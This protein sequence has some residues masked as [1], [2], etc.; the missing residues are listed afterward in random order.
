MSSSCS[1]LWLEVKDVWFQGLKRHRKRVHPVLGVDGAW[2][3]GAQTGG[4]EDNSQGRQGGGCLFI[5]PQRLPSWGLG[6][7][8]MDYTMICFCTEVFRGTV[9][10][11]KMAFLPT[12]NMMLLRTHMPNLF[13]NVFGKKVEKRDSWYWSHGV[14]HTQSFLSLC[15]P[16]WIF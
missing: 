14:K 15:R 16:F 9:E 3:P 4:A 7:T 13:S 5:S 1:L 12:Q 8:L 6:M 2:L 10:H 11:A